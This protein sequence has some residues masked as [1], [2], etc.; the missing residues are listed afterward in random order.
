MNQ[1]IILKTFNKNYNQKQCL[2]ALLKSIILNKSDQKSEM[3]WETLKVILFLFFGYI[4]YRFALALKR[5]LE[6]EA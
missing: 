6:W 4:A 2:P 5:Q 1:K 3:I